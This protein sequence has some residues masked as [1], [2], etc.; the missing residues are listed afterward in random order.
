M[1]SIQEAL[2]VREA[3]T[4]KASSERASMVEYFVLPLK[5]ER[6]AENFERFKVFLKKNPK[7]TAEEFKKTKE[8]LRPLTTRAIAVMLSKVKT[9]ELYP[10]F[11]RC[12]EYKGGFSR[13]FFGSLKNR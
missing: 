3:P 2:Q 11:K 8:Y 5:E 9:E 4:S 7:K 12:C 1:K 10:F 6:R 13:A